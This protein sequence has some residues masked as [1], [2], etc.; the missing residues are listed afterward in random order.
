MKRNLL[1]FGLLCLMMVFAFIAKAQDVTA[2]WN[3]KANL[4]E[5]IQSIQVE[6]SVRAIAS[7]V[8]GI[9]M[10][11]DATNGKLKP[12]CRCPDQQGNHP[13][14]SGEIIQR[15]RYHH[16]LWQREVSCYFHHR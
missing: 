3:F 13:E 14:G 6:K 4:P 12:L 11:V 7:T 1:R 9:E 10:T 16:E 15:H 8:E 2:E 5:G